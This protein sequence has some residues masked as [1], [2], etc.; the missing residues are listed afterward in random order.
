MIP[1]LI[2]AL[3]IIPK[4]LVKGVVDLKI[5][6][7]TET[8]QTIALLRMARILKKQKRFSEIQTSANVDVENFQK[9]KII[10]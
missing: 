6:G 4:G 8:L 1:I 10:K 5:R 2:G 7:N 3:G 9:H